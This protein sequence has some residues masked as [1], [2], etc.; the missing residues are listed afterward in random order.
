MLQSKAEQIVCCRAKLSSRVLWSKLKMSRS[1][2][3]NVQELQSAVEQITAHSQG[4][5]TTYFMESIM[6]LSTVEECR[7]AGKSRTFP[8]MVVWLVN[9]VARNPH[10]RKFLYSA[11]PY[12]MDIG[13]TCAKSLELGPRCDHGLPGQPTYRFLV[14]IQDAVHVGVP[15]IRAQM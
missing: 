5:E 4:I 7:L 1:Q 13:R 12:R 10:P 6:S 11:C 15:P 14:V 8:S 9:Y 2:F 3:R